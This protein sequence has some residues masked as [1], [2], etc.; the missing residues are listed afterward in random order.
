VAITLLILIWRRAK[1]A[2][3]PKMSFF[4]VSFL[5]TTLLFTGWGLYWGGFPQFTDIGWF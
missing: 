5:V 2:Y 1:L 4:F 3:Q